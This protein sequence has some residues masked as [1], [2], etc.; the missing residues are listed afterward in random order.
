MREVNDAFLQL[1]G[2]A[3]EEVVG[4]HVLELG[5]WIDPGGATPPSRR[6]GGARPCGT[7]PRACASRAGAILYT[8]L[9]DPVV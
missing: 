3:R 7:S 8:A 2:F 9:A 1:H 4:R 5:L 6:S